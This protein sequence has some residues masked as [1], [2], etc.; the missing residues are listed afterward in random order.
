LVKPKKAEDEAYLSF[1]EASDNEYEYFVKRVRKQRPDPQSN[2]QRAN[3][4]EGPFKP[5]SE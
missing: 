5:I 1:S 2:E 3:K 4:F